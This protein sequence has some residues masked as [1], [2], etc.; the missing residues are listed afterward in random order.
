MRDRFPIDIDGLDEETIRLLNEIRGKDD[1]DTGARIPRDLSK[2]KVSEAVDLIR[3]L[4]TASEFGKDPP[5]QSNIV[6]RQLFATLNERVAQVS[7]DLPRLLEQEACLAGARDAARDQYIEFLKERSRLGKPLVYLG[8]SLLIYLACLVVKPIVVVA[9]GTLMSL[10][11]FWRS[12]L[13]RTARAAFYVRLAETL[14]SS[15]RGIH[16]P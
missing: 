9:I 16:K 8:A 1:T 15:R 11:A 5:S 7:P 2:L 6:A 3:L 13:C 10:S 12:S 4:R 14:E